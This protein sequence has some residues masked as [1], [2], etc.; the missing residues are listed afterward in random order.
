MYTIIVASLIDLDLM[1]CTK[2]KYTMINK[3]DFEFEVNTSDSGVCLKKYLGHKK[4]IYIPDYVLNRK[5]TRIESAAFSNNDQIKIIIL[6]KNVTSILEEAF[7]NTDHL[8][9][10]TP[11]EQ[12]EIDLKHLKNVNIRYGF[13][14]IMEYDSILYALF[15]NGDAFVCDHRLDE[16]RFERFG[17]M[18]EYIVMQTIIDEVFVVKGIEPYALNNI[19]NLKNIALPKQLTFIGNKAF[20]NDDQLEYITLPDTLESIDDSAFENC[21][22]LKLVEIPQSV[23]KIGEN[24]FK[25]VYRA[26]IF[27]ENS[28]TYDGMSN[29]WNP[30]ELPVFNSF[31]DYIINEDILYA[32]LN[33]KKAIIVGN[34]LNTIKDVVIPDSIEVD[35]TNYQ[36]NEIGRA[37]FYECKYIRSISLPDS[38]T[39]IHDVAFAYSNLKNISLPVNLRYLGKGVFINNIFLERIELPKHIDIVTEN[40]FQGC[41]SLERVQLPDRVRVIE[42]A[43]F[44]SCYNLYDMQMP[45]LVESIGAY[46]FYGTGIPQIDLGYQINEVKELAFGEMENLSSLTILNIKCEVPELIITREGASIYI[47]GDDNTQLFLN[48]EENNKIP[49]KIYTGAYKIQVINSIKYLMT[50]FDTAIVI[51]YVPSKKENHIKVKKNIMISR[52]ERIIRHSFYKAPYIKTIYIPEDVYAI[53]CD[54]VKQCKSL[55]KITIPEHID[56]TKL[57]IPSGVYVDVYQSNQEVSE[58]LYRSIKDFVDQKKY[59]NFREISEVFSLNYATTK[60]V[61]E[62]LKKES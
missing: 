1:N 9:L 20:Y 52:V 45:S 44:H 8:I 25:N 53:D 55:K 5:V 47:A 34:Q 36:V 19:S 2:E 40:L 29:D 28:S 14:D 59:I 38:I 61:I 15:K 21:S 39:K 4:V 26:N 51:G 37:A 58:I 30:E 35:G 41:I 49:Y 18:G 17:R 6:S 22:D 31:R 13:L 50:V 12:H 24:A 33:D 62:R 42:D 10:Y 11:Y 7:S 56:Y 23:I 43:A 54:F 16:R 57:N 60:M 46:A 48:L 27:I 32:L 3:C